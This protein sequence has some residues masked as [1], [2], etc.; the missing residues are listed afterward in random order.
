MENKQE[1]KEEDEPCTCKKC[2]KE[3]NQEDKEMIEKRGR[4]LEFKDGEKGFIIVKKKYGDD[5]TAIIGAMKGSNLDFVEI[6]KNLKIQGK[7]GAYDKLLSAITFVE[8]TDGLGGL[9]DIWKS[10]E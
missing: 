1:E 8:M 5:R 3:I 4:E 9:K 7:D 10:K 6:L 2:K